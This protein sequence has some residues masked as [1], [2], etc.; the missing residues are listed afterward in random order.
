MIHNSIK[1]AKEIALD[2]T[3]RGLLTEPETA[4]LLYEGLDNYNVFAQQFFCDLLPPDRTRAVRDD[5]RLNDDSMLKLWGLNTCFVSSSADKEGDLFIDP[6]SL[7]ITREQ[8]VTNVVVAHHPLSWLRQKQQL[9]DHLNDVAPIQIFGHVH[10]NRIHMNRD[11]IRVTAGA[12]HPDRQE[13]GWEP[14]Y[15]L[16]DLHV[17][18]DNGT[19]WLHVNTHVRVWQTAPGGFQPK[20]DRRRDVFEHRILLEPWESS[21]ART[22]PASST[23][24]ASTDAHLVVPEVAPMTRLRE[25]GIRFYR[26]SFSKKSEIAG[27]LNLLEA[28]D[29]TQP[30]FERFRR[31]L[32]RAHER[33]KVGELENAISEAEEVGGS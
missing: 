12:T 17:E 33:G 29:M 8:G 14:G 22:V 13:P 7:Q 18:H 6:A 25:I 3:I 2:A 19:R 9:E 31:V 23:G 15:N 30:D 27:R 21:H 20:K 16:I 10:T 32:F 11:W 28:E 26:L 24:S 5:L 4:R 1:E